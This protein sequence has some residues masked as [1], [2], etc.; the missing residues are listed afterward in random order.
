[1]PAWKLLL[2]HKFDQLW[3]QPAPSTHQ[4][5]IHPASQPAIHSWARKDEEMRTTQRLTSESS[6]LHSA[7]WVGFHEAAR[8]SGRGPCWR[9]PEL[10]LVHPEPGLAGLA[11]GLLVCRTVSWCLKCCSDF[12]F[13]GPLPHWA[14]GPPL[15]SESSSHFQGPRTLQALILG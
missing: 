1:M 15:C 13:L 3:P 12:T 11:E 6:Q 7:S 9:S 2:H 4:A 5:S 14:R 10:S 8:R